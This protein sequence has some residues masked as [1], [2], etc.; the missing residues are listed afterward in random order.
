V[1]AL[2]GVAVE[3]LGLEWL[4]VRDAEDE[5]VRIGFCVAVPQIEQQRS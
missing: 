2:V 1:P 4:V 5:R 3:T